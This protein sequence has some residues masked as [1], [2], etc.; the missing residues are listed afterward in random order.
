LGVTRVDKGLLHLALD[1]VD[2]LFERS[3]VAAQQVV[4]ADRTM[5]DGRDVRVDGVFHVAPHRLS[6]RDDAHLPLEDGSNELLGPIV[7]VVGAEDVDR[8]QDHG[9]KTALHRC[10]DE[11]LRQILGLA[12]VVMAARHRIRWRALVEPAARL[13][14]V[15]ADRRRVDEALRSLLNGDIEHVPRPDDVVLVLLRVVCGPRARVRRE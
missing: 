13:V 12:V 8:V 11:L 10:L 3:L 6:R 1:L 7:D 15:R 14:A 2:H 5:I 9:G 4:L